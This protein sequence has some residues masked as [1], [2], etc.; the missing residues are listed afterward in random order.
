[1]VGVTTSDI[2]NDNAMVKDTERLRRSIS[3]PVVLGSIKPTT[4]IDITISKQK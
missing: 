1:M 4:P 2:Y 3:A